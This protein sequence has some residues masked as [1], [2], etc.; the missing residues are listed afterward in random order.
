VPH[1]LTDERTRK[2]LTR[3]LT[4]AL[5]QS[6]VLGEVL[7][8]WDDGFNSFYSEALKAIGTWMGQED[9]TWLLMDIYREA[10][11][12]AQI[13]KKD[14]L[15]SV[16]EVIGSAQIDSLVATIIDFL[17][18]I[19]VEYEISYPLPS[20][21]RIDEE[22]ALTEHVRL[23]PKDERQP[24][25]LLDTEGAC[26]SV[27]VTGYANGSLQHSAVRDA[28]A[29]LKV[30]LRL[31]AIR[32]LFFEGRRLRRPRFS[33][34]NENVETEVA[35]FASVREVE[36]GKATSVKLG[37]GLSKYIDGIRWNNRSEKNLVEDF[38]D[39][40]EPLR[41]MYSS[42]AE[43]NVRSIRR[44]IE[45]QFDGICDEDATTRFIK[46]CIGLEALLAEQSEEMGITEQLAD[47]CAFLLGDTAEERAQRRTMMREVYKLRSKIV[48]GSVS[49]LSHKDTVISSR[50]SNLLISLLTV[51]LDSVEKWWARRAKTASKS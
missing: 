47:R 31:G 28:A 49:G 20:F 26:I 6:R 43:K 7:W 36:S 13:A 10:V 17:A 1:S 9:L 23:V 16:Q 40:S 32:K 14:Q 39:L 29:I 4:E 38:I 19:P 21:P 3:K 2:A 27:R 18:R 41:M 11:R 24:R 34:H 22:I 8:A 51:E 45:W 46:H 12:S 37:V 5:A 42:D 33:I 35:H 30:V 44:A 48:H 15:L 25:A 50:A